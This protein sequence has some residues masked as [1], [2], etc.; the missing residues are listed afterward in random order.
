VGPGVRDEVLTLARES[1]GPLGFAPRVI[2]DGPIDTTVDE[3]TAEELLAT[4]REA[5]SN[6]VRHAAASQV[7]I[8][9]FAGDDVVLRVSDDGRGFEATSAGSGYGL[10]NMGERAHSLGGQL[11]VGPASGGGTLVEWK[12]PAKRSED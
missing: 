3:R 4:L 11:D 7:E 6:V 12:V 8:E 1:A 10:R 5:L 2:F 9:V